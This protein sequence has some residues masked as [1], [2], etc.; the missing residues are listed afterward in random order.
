MKFFENFSLTQFFK[1]KIFFYLLSRYLTYFIQFISSVYIAVRLGPYYFGIWG[2]ILLLITYF[3][4]INFGISYSNNILL[5]QNKDNKPLIKNIVA[6]S[7]SLIGI[8]AILIIILAILV[9]IY[10]I[11]IFNKY[12]LGNIIYLVLIIAVF[13]QLN[14]L[15]MVIYR[16]QNKIFHIAFNQSIVPF[17]IFIS[18][19]IFKKQS[20][21]YFLVITYIVGHILTMLI[22]FKGKLIPFGGKPSFHTAKLV[23]KKGILLFVYNSSFYFI[24]ISIKTIVSIYYPVM[25]FGFFSFSFSLANSVM[26]SINA[27][28]FLF[29]SK[30]I[31]NFVPNDSIRAKST[32]IKIRSTYVPLTHIFIYLIITIY[33]FVIVYVPKY[34]NTTLTFCLIAITL[35]LQSNFY[36]QTSFLMAK[37]KEKLLAYISLFILILNIGIALTI[38]KIFEANYQYVIISTQI[39][40]LIFSYLCVYYSKKDLMEHTSFQEVLKDWLPTNLL[41]PYTLA[42]ALIMFGYYNFLILPL[43]L[44]ILLNVKPLNQIK[45]TIV[46]MLKNPNIIDVN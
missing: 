38:V 26:L 40:Y 43:I 13:L 29:F 1:N 45:E 37:N 2:F 12:E 5:I 21:L 20:L 10:E 27:M 44:F 25:E 42:I 30:L 28:T 8:Y 7:L 16:V 35:I 3:G 32:I 6:T 22:Y 39:S 19:F 14:Q 24:I 34:Q 4:Q 9:S 41:L 36:A 18:I 15:F 11:A 31:N 23:L 17:L 33:P 46:A